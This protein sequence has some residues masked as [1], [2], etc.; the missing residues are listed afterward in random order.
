MNL[1]FITLCCLLAAA[2]SDS[3]NS[4]RESKLPSYD[5][6]EVDN[7][8]SD[9]IEENPAFE[10]TSIIVVE[11]E[12]GVIHEAAFGDHTLD[13]IVMLA[14]ASKVPTVSLL[15]AMDGDSS[16]DFDVSLPIENYLPWEGVYSGI[17]TEH[18]VS[19]QS[20]IPGLLFIDSYGPHLCQHVPSGQLQDCGQTIFQT[21]LPGT[22]EPGSHFDYGG[23]QW[24]LSG[25]VAEVV[26]GASWAQLF[27]SYIA[28]PC[29]L[30]VFQYGNM[31]L[32]FSAWTGS[33][34]SLTGMDNPNIEGGG[35][36]NLQ[37][38]GKILLMHLNDGYCGENQVLSS[39]A[40]E[41]MRTDRGSDVGSREWLNIGM[42]NGLGWWVIPANE[43][44]E[45]TM[46]VDPGVFGSVLWLDSEREYAAYIAFEDY[47]LEHASEAR[48]MVLTELI[49]VVGVAIDEARR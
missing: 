22:V 3:G 43:G 49:E 37:D 17:T 21:L 28:E 31:F 48:A 30:D 25:A 20:G 47:T 39:A 36:S 5:F 9:F 1:L 44:S 8:L 19:N 18:L 2:C 23:S 13:T 11:K 24:Q 41:S 14:S 12:Q 16:M 27:D 6:T 32:D 38:M 26:G 7:R 10:G 29:D 33:S 45:P 4:S 34:D 42:G 35:I 40:V 46:F 15:M